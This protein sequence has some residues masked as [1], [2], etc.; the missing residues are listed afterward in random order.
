MRPRPL[1]ILLLLLAGAVVNV[2]VAWSPYW[3]PPRRTTQTRA[4]DS[5][6]RDRLVSVYAPAGFA[7]LPVGKQHQWSA[8]MTRRVAASSVNT[9]RAVWVWEDKTGWPIHCLGGGG[10]TSGALLLQ[11]K[12]PFATRR[13]INGL[14]LP[15]GLLPVGFGFNT[16]F[17][18]A[19][20]WLLFLFAPLTLRRRLRAR[21]G[22][23]PA[24]AY[25][26]GDA[27]VCSE[28][29]KAATANTTTA[30]TWPSEAG[31]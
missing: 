9:S 14:G 24:C 7:E 16:L 20:L 25:P 6:D 30:P 22:L 8:L 1:T 26:V 19:L 23:C 12:A 29:G 5:Y 31:E 28:C 18:A 10:A 13:V 2:G 21:R 11:G 17:Y 15:I 3:L 27:A 4:L